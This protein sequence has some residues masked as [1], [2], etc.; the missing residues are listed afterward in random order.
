[1]VP[2]RQYKKQNLGNSTT[3]RSPI[4]R[5][6]PL[7]SQQTA[8]SEMLQEK[9]VVSV[10]ENYL[11]FARETRY[12]TQLKCTQPTHRTFYIM[13]SMP[14]IIEIQMEQLCL[15]EEYKHLWG[16]LPIGLSQGSDQPMEITRSSGSPCRLGGVAA[17]S[18]RL[19]MECQ[20]RAFGD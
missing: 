6:D 7:Y 12:C 9:K 2:F 15:P 5:K 11:E 1:M 18:M 13:F 19:I 10:L 17:V 4:T 14:I 8:T 16:S 20:G 3:W